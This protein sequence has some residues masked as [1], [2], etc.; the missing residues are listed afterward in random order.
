MILDHL[1]NWQLYRICRWEKI[2]ESSV[3][4]PGVWV[5]YMKVKEW[6]DNL[7]SLKATEYVSYQRDTVYQDSISVLHKKC[8]HSTDTSYMQIML[9]V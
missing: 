1:C 2:V 6:Y 3:N 9:T 8:L 4:T 7:Q 5:Q